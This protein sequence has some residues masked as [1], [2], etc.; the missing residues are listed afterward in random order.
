MRTT[1]LFFAYLFLCLAAAALLA[2]PLMQTGWVDYPPERVMGRLAQVLILLGI[3]PLLLRLQLA[4][5]A[6]LGYGASRPAFLRAL[7]LGWVLG[8][9]ILLGLALALLGLAVRVP[10]PEPGSWS[11]IAGTAAQALIG[12]LL[13]GF[14]EETFFRG[15][16]FAAIRRRGGLAPAVLWSSALYAVL[17]L[18]KPGALPPGVPFDWAGSWAMFTG[19]FL[20]VFQWRHLDTALALMMVGIF[21]ALVREGTGHIG[22]CIGLHA[23]WVF[24]I[25][26][27]R[28]LTDG[29]PSSDLAF[30]TGDYDGIIGWL[31][32][33]WIGVLSAGYWR[34][35]SRHRT[36]EA[37]ESA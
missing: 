12:G 13:V 7:G 10:D 32:L 6:D 33:A 22:W 19:V 27:T 4:N 9:L 34:W 35:I 25:Q 18:L 5:R 20:D 30:L 21:L 28:R 1:A 37:A 24:V 31:S 2:V 16:V 15:A 17:H 8:V 23:G 29:N 26:L 3:W 11:W 36:R 14:L